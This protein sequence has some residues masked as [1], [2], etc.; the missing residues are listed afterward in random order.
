MARITEPKIEYKVLRSG[1]YVCIHP[2]TY[3]SPR[4]C[5]SVTVNAG[6]ISDGATG[7]ID[8]DSDAWWIH[9]VLCERGTWDD[10]SPVTNWQASMVL[11][12]ILKE[13]GH[14]WRTYT[15]KWM[16]YFFGGTKLSTW[17]RD[18]LRR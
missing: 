13:E 16:T 14:H 2:L 12:D 4:Y 9:D 8:I 18:L 5:K 7:A 6:F 15:W 11:S 10:K 1:K 3:T 17:W